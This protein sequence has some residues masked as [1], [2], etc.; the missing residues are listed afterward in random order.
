MKHRRIITIFDTPFR[1]GER[2]GVDVIEA[3][4]AFFSPGDCEGVRAVSAAVTE[5]TICSFARAHAE[6]LDA[7]VEALVDAR[8]RNRTHVV[9]ATRPIHTLYDV[10]EEVA[11]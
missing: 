6:D 9:V 1:D 2:L 7:A 10:F 8:G 4:F 3:G 5:P 11:A